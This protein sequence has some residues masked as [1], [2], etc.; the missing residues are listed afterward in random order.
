MFRRGRAVVLALVSMT[1]AD[2]CG[3]PPPPAQPPPVIATPDER[4]LVIDAR[5][6]AHDRNFEA[7]DRKYEQAYGVARSFDVLSERVELLLHIGH[8]TRGQ[9]IARQY[10]DRNPTD[11]RGSHLYA[12]ALIAGNKGQEALHVI[13]QLLRT[14]PQDAAAHDKRGRALSLYGTTQEALDELRQAVQL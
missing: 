14:N 12:E 10:C 4:L 1:V 8:A 9:E 2:A 13:D 11:A 3:G 5:R 7:A 6:H